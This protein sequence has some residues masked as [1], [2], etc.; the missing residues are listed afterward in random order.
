MKRIESLLLIAFGL[1]FL[2]RLSLILPYRMYSAYVFLALSIFYLFWGIGAMREISV[3]EY[4]INFKNREI[5]WNGLS[6]GIGCSLAALGLF[7]MENLTPGYRFILWSGVFFILLSFIVEVYRFMHNEM[8][9]GRTIRRS[10]IWLALCFTFLS[11]SEAFLVKRIYK[12]HPR[13]LQLYETH[14]KYPD[15]EAYREMFKKEFDRVEE[16]MRRQ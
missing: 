6:Q 13:L 4:F 15:N 3:K 12:D 7:C 5:H 16:T 11:S 9:I 1:T 10:F 14:T 8:K 2:L